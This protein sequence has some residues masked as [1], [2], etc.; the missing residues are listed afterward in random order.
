MTIE[1]DNRTQEQSISNTRT[2]NIRTLEHTKREQLGSFSCVVCDIQKDTFKG[3]P[4]Q[5]LDF[6]QR[7]SKVTLNISSRILKKKKESR[8]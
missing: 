1:H 5:N 4:P 7:K 8:E 2:Q 6:K 3:K